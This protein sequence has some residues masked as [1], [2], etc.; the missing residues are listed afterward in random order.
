MS[1]R[2]ALR[3]RTRE[4]IRALQDDKLRRFVTKKVYPFHP[5]YHRLFDENKIDPESIR[6]VIHQV[7]A[8]RP[9]VEVMLM[10]PVMTKDNGLADEFT[11]LDQVLNA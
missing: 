4:E 1:P 8:A 6:T 3:L 10:S 11:L 5:Y 9:Q 7:R 2:R